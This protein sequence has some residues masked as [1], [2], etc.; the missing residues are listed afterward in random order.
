MRNQVAVHALRARQERHPCLRRNQQHYHHC[1][2]SSVFPDSTH[3]DGSFSDN[4][5]KV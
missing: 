2:G 5:E 4:H 1:R 3:A